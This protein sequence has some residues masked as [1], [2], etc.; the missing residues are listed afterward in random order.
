MVT[1]VNKENQ[2][3][4]RRAGQLL[5]IRHRSGDRYAIPFSHLR[6]M[7]FGGLNFIYAN[8]YTPLPKGHKYKRIDKS[9]GL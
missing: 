4:I 8:E 7:I 9:E 2:L 6:A 1:K 3:Y 5:T